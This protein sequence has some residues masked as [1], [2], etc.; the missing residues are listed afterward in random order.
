MESNRPTSVTVFGVVDVVLGV[1][2][3]IGVP[4]AWG[5]FLAGAGGDDPVVAVTMASPFLRGWFVVSLILGFVMVNV[6][7]LAGVRLL[8]LRPWARTACIVF[9]IYAIVT[10]VAGMILRLAV[11]FPRVAELTQQAAEPQAA[12]MMAGMAG[13]ACRGVI[14]LVYPILLLIFMMRPKVVAAFRK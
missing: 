13:R 7:I 12:G 14:G 11:V 9:A 5:E 4:A 6:L 3:L 8:R 10:N 2:G 1:L